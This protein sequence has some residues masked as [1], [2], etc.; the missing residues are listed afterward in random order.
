MNPTRLVAG[1]SL[2]DG[3][4]RIFQAPVPAYRWHRKGQRRRCL[5][6]PWLAIAAALIGAS[7]GAL[8]KAVL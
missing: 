2:V 1:G 4:P 3:P 8:A 7:L 6:S 5:P